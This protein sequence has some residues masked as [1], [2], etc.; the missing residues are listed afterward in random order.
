MTSL[1][2]SIELSECLRY[3]DLAVAEQ[4]F[5]HWEPGDQPPT[6]L[7]PEGFE[8]R[9]LGVL[10]SFEN[11]HIRVPRIVIG[12]YVKDPDLNKHYRTRFEALAHELAPGAWE[13]IENHDNGV[14]VQE[15]LDRV[16]EPTVA[17][18]ITGL[19]SRG[20]FGA[21]DALSASDRDAMI[22]YSSQAKKRSLALSPKAIS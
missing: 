8:E 22:L 5:C 6:L 4:A 14:W 1:V 13:V 2:S 12:R 3:A 10:Q 17:L 11:R 19:S 9:S 16:Q 20:L 21:L 7:V 15:A 18:D